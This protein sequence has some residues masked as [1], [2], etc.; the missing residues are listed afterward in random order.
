MTKLNKTKLARIEAQVKE[1]EEEI[2]LQFLIESDDE[3]IREAL[4]QALTVVK[5]IYSEEVD[6]QARRIRDDL[7]REEHD[8]I[9]RKRMDKIRQNEMI[10]EARRQK[11]IAED[12]YLY[13]KLNYPAWPNSQTNKDWCTNTWIDDDFDKVYELQK[14][15]DSNKKNKKDPPF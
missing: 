3:N 10:E 9:N 6:E 1:H 13:K 12:D 14:I 2:L 11:K 4:E 8:E 15:F 5:L 7:I